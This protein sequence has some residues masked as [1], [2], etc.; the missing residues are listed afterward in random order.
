MHTNSPQKKWRNTCTQTHQKTHQ[1]RSGEIH[2]DNSPKKEVEKYMQTNS[3][4]VYSRST[5]RVARWKPLPLHA[6]SIGKEVAI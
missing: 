3:Q 5:S 4:K 6:R 2:A 1:K